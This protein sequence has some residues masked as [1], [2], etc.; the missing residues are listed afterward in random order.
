MLSAPLNR[1]NPRTK[2]ITARSGS[3]RQ[4]R[5]PIAAEATTSSTSA[6]GSCSVSTP[7]RSGNPCRAGEAGVPGADS[8]T[9]ADSGSKV[10]DSGIEAPGRDE[11]I[12]VDLRP[13]GSFAQLREDALKPPPQG[14]YRQRVLPPLTWIN[15]LSNRH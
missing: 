10:A 4:R 3:S 1:H 8:G 2:Y 7:S 15:A 14:A 5:F 9:A 12:L 13:T 6:T 11:L